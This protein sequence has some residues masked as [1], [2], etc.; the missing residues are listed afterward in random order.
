[1]SRVV[2][3]TIKVIEYLEALAFLAEKELSEE[4]LKKY[5][6]TMPKAISCVAQ[7]ISDEIDD[8]ELLAR[9]RNELY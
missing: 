1:M 2:I 8:E 9:F 6:E 3:D 7:Y 4:E 5:D